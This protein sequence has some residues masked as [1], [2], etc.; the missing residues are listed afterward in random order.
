MPYLV[1]T[2]HTLGALIA[3]TAEQNEIK[4]DCTI[5]MEVGMSP[6]LSLLKTSCTVHILWVYGSFKLNYCKEEK[7]EY[8]GDLWWTSSW[9]WVL[10]HWVKHFSNKWKLSAVF[11]FLIP[12]RPN[13][14]TKEVGLKEILRVSLAYHDGP[15]NVQAVCI[16][17]HL[18][19]Q[20][21]LQIWQ[22]RHF[23][24]RDPK[25]NFWKGHF[26]LSCWQKTLQLLPESYLDLWR[27]KKIAAGRAPCPS[28]ILSLPYKEH[29]Q[30]NCNSPTSRKSHRWKLTHRKLRNMPREVAG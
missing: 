8:S 23:P 10:G 28:L 14:S 25:P 18:S 16:N 24:C 12:R 22:W 11:F 9:G 21:N 30:F 1:K 6:T 26:A 7:L 5:R 3:A 27:E 19:G 17:N 2:F 13:E 20:D 29:G 4:N 15:T